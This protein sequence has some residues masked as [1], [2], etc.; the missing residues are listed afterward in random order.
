MNSKEVL[1]KFYFALKRISIEFLS[2][3]SV[4]IRWNVILM[5]DVDR[6]WWKFCF[7]AEF[8]KTN[9]SA[10]VVAHSKVIFITFYNLHTKE[11]TD[12]W[13]NL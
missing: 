9:Y 8:F 1:K 3:L 12:E 5:D 6:E 13:S 4:A 2:S 11:G 10:Y 7:W